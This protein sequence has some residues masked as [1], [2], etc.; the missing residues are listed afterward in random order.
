MNQ[1]QLCINTTFL[2]FKFDLHQQNESCNQEDF[3]WTKISEICFLGSGRGGRF[4]LTV[5]IIGT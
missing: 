5:I 4:F 2:T 3:S 1:F